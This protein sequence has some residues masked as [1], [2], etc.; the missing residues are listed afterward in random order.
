[1]KK[2]KFVVLVLSLLFILP[3]CVYAEEDD[4]VLVD[5]NTKYLKTITYYNN[6]IYNSGEIL[7]NMYGA[8]ST[9]YE[10][11]EEEYN[12]A[13]ANGFSNYVINGSTTI[14]TTYK[15][16]TTSLV[17]NGSYFRYKNVLNWKIMPAVRSNDIIGIGFLGNVELNGNPTFELK[18]CLSGGSCYYNHNNFYP[19]TFSNGASATFNLPNSTSV[20]LLRVTYYFDVKKKNPSNT[21]YSQAAYGDYA[22]ATSSTNIILALDH[23]VIQNVGIVFDDL[24]V[25]SHYDSIPE[26]DVHWYGTW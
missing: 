5:E 8:S 7:S 14:E 20:N 11:T 17:S 19:Q 26:A 25:E 16:M 21:I 15:C 1:M 13:T 24:N 23:Q 4:W 18:Y 10:I 2:I 6:N 12:Q 3:T 9:T 22:H